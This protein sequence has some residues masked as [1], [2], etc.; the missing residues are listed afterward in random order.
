MAH[1][2]LAKR[3]GL[4]SV[5]VLSPRF[6]DWK[7]EHADPFRRAA[8]RLGVRIAGT[9]VY[10]PEAK[11]YDALAG[12]VARSG[13]RGVFL[14]GGQAEGAVGPLKALRARLG[15]RVQIL[16]ADVLAEGSIRGLLEVAGPAARGVYM[17]ATDVPPGARGLSA[18]GRRFARDFGA[19]ESPVPGVLQ[20]AQSAEVVLQA[21]A[22]SD[23]TRASVLRELRATQ[24]KNGLLGSFRFDR[25][26]DITPARIPIYRVTGRTPAHAGLYD[27]FQG[28]VIDRVVTV[29]AAM[30]E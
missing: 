30:A 7:T 20:A 9:E 14:A 17:G 23:G 11:S 18:A 24:V 27:G 6:G 13:A 16:A 21:I 19:F 1:A 5:Y 29:P 2:M 15:T 26:G 3:L 28:A 4:K 22:R 8:L 12:R 10:P 25:N